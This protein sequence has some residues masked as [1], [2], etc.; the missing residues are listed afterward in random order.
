MEE[1]AFAK[2]NLALH[3]R[4]REP[5]GYH[6]IETVFAF[7]EEGDV[8]RVRKNDHLILEVEGPFAGQVSEGQD[9]LVL[10]SAMALQQH[11]GGV[12]GAA[13]TLQKNLPIASGVGGGSA[14]AAA[15]LRLL[16]RFWQLPA[17]TDNLLEVAKSLGSDVPACLLSRPARGEGRGEQLAPLSDWPLAGV[18]VLLVNPGTALATAAVFHGWD[19]QDR[20]PLGDPLAGRNDLEG[21]A[22]QLVPEIANVL[23]AL[24][25]TG[26][27]RLVRMSGSGATCFALYETDAARDAALSQITAVNPDWW[28]LASRLKG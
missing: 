1:P 11:F 26:G 8:L 6:R 23:A 12:Q 5:D 7:I 19:G 22:Q 14:D 25:A 10:Q 20:G 3:V 13:L 24:R 21:S 28:L 4:S 9:N 2:L 27:T 15:A 17:S 16:T 18:P